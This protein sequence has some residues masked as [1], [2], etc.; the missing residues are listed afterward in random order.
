MAAKRNSRLVTGNLKASETIVA[1]QLCAM[2]GLS[3]YDELSTAL[4]V[5]GER[6]SEQMPLFGSEALRLFPWVA[7]VANE[8]MADKATALKEHLMLHEG[9]IFIVKDRELSGKE[10]LWLAAANAGLFELVRDSPFR[11]ITNHS[12]EDEE[13]L[14]LEAI[15]IT[16]CLRKI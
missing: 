1:A 9:C 6:C 15:Q 8:I 7:S 2:F 4:E 14:R 16:S 13:L 3:A 5:I 12:I 10:G 11:G